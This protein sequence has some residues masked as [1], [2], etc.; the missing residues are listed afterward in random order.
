MNCILM[1]NRLRE[2][3]DKGREVYQRISAVE[4]ALALPLVVGQLSIILQPDHGGVEGG[5][6]FHLALKHHVPVP[7]HLLILRLL[8][9]T[10]RLC[11]RTHSFRRGQKLYGILFICFIYVL[12]L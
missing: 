12:D 9:N 3:E 10:G 4:E 1:S 2:K 11:Q 6:V 8:Q 5:V 7:L